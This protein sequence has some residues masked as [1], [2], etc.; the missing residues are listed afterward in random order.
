[1]QKLKKEM[2]KHKV[3]DPTPF[4]KMATIKEKVESLTDD[5]QCPVCGDYG[6]NEF[7]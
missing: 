6:T 2:M 3:S 1:M 4:K 5:F 7:I